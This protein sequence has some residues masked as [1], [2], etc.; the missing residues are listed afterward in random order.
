M[1]K[2]MNIRDA[3][4]MLIFYYPEEGKQSVWFCR[5]VRSRV[6]RLVKN[7]KAMR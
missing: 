5:P 1:D 6:R 3:S 7:W 2:A 4:D